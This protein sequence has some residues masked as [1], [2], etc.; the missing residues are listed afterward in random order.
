[1]NEEL[2]YTT[3]EQSMPSYLNSQKANAAYNI[4]DYEL[5][6]YFYDKALEDNP[7]EIENLYHRGICKQTLGNLK[8][9]CADWSTIKSLGNKIADELLLKYCRYML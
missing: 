2:K 4:R 3:T 1:M 6:L 8:G 5:A 9:A 7:K